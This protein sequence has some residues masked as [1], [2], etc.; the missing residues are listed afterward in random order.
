VSTAHYL[1]TVTSEN[2]ASLE[3]WLG[4]AL[5]I[6]PGR[7][8]ERNGAD[9]SVLVAGLDAITGEEYE[10]IAKRLRTSGPLYHVR[11]PG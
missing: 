1:L 5:K 3:R 6:G 7:P 4:G 11:G 9:I 2:A 8:G 10:V